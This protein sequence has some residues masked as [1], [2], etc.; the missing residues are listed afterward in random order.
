MNE[1]PLPTVT[2]TI[3][4]VSLPTFYVPQRFMTPSIPVDDAMNTIHEP[5]FMEVDEQTKS[6]LK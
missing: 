2:S 4:N 6:Q 3:F 5:L 1:S